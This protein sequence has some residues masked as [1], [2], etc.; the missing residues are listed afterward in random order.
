MRVVQENGEKNTTSESCNFNAWFAHCKRPFALQVM[1][2]LILFINIYI[3]VKLQ[4]RLKYIIFVCNKMI[5][6]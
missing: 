3:K 1:F 6:A 2:V 5:L 4:K